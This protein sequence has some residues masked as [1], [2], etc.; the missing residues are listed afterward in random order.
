MARILW[1][2]TALAAAAFA[3]SDTSTL[4][5]IVR[6]ASDAT[7]AGASVVIRNEATGFERRTAT[8]DTGY[9][10]IASVPSGVYEVTVE[11]PGFKRYRETGRK[12]DPN[13]AATLAV[14]MQVGSVQESVS[15]VASAAEVQ[16][17]TATVGRIITTEQVNSLQLNG[18][19]PM[20]LAQ[21]APGV[22]RRN[23]IS[24]F[25]FGMDN[26]FFINGARKEE[27]NITFDG[28]PAVRTRSAGV[29]IGV[30]DLDATQEVQILTS[31]YRAEYGRASGGQMRIITK[32]GSKDFHGSFYEYFRNSALDAN[33]WTRNASGNPDF[34]SPAPFRFNQ[35]GYS[36][37]GPVL[38]PG[39]KFNRNRN[40]LFWLFGQEFVKYRQDQTVTRLVPSTA[41]RQGD[42]SELLSATNRYYGRVVAVRDPLNNTPFAGNI[43]PANRLSSSGI[44]LI[45]AFPTPTPGF[46]QGN[47]NWI[48]AAGAPQNQRKETVSVD[49]SPTEKHNFRFRFLNYN[50]DQTIPFQGGYDRGPRI[51]IRPNKVG[52]IN[53][54]W[55][56]NPSTVNELL[57]SASHD[58]TRI[59]LDTSSG[60]YERTQYGITY[61]FLFPNGKLTEN[62]IPAINIAGLTTLTTS[63][64]G[65]T[66]GPI[67]VISN[68][69]SKVMS[70]HTFKA[71]FVY[72]YAGQND[73]NQNVQ[74]GNFS[75]TDNRTG[76][77]TS[78]AAMAN[79]ALGMFDSY[80]EIGALNYI[81]YRAQMFEYFA[82]D[83]WKITQKFNLE[84]GLRHSLIQPWYSQWGNI[85]MFDSRFY[86][87]AKIPTLD[88]RTGRIL[89]GSL[90][91]GIVIPGDGF[92][93]AVSG[94]LPF[95]PATAAGLFR[96]LG[97]S[98]SVFHKTDFQP[99]VGITYAPTTRLVFRAGIGRYTLRPPVSDNVNPGANL[100]F[101]QSAS[102]AIG[103]VDSPGGGSTVSNPPQVNTWDATFRNPNAW[104]WNASAEW[105]VSQSTLLS[106]GYVARRG[107][108]NLFRDRNMNQL[109]PGTI[110]RNPGINV[111]FLRPFHGFGDI[112]LTNNDARSIYQ[113]LQM[114]LTRRY[115]KG[116][117]YGVAYTYSKAYDSGSSK[118]DILPNA[119]DA[120]NYWGPSANDFRNIL[121]VNFAYDLPFFANASRVPRALLGG[122]Q[123][124]GITQFQSGPPLTIQSAEDFAG[125][126]PG[127]GPQIWNVSGNPKLSGGER[128]FADAANLPNYWFRA[129]DGNGQSLFTPPATGTFTTQRNRNLI[130]GPG[131]QDWNL[132]VAKAFAF[133]ENHRLQFRAEVFNWVNHPNWAQPAANPRNLTTLGKITSK[134]GERNLQLSLRY[135]F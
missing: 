135:S 108:N 41:I 35:F 90:T 112:R 54:I 60:R 39:T 118:D 110:Q 106:V 22:I 6:D 104:N 100:P 121:I 70:R 102:I 94:R 5:G 105:G 92:P 93:E 53:Y 25:T 76:G 85:S 3:Q 46:S 27:T 117:L 23:S 18:R 114:N 61:P 124:A 131:F 19:N 57:V 17:E 21:L 103:P 109:Q 11:A 9:F 33:S 72:E 88:P 96:G 30:P 68:N 62:V 133:S 98:Y 52:S 34:A 65:L 115:S 64:P 37:S 71:G 125:V 1:A 128:K 4:S 26:N 51:L 13:I 122:W 28:A 75:F 50:Y 86:D 81:P 29:P 123:I 45:R 12:I 2:A 78:G 87:P 91:N 99:R 134:S 24:S 58:R 67:Y 44:G 132:S 10:A 84:Y 73:G 48:A 59:L 83:S 47:N 107:L 126:G 79:A 95:D 32:S 111:N 15:V 89:S 66:A 8:N 82:Q 56:V 14:S 120:S 101:Q 119:Y 74:S 69:F 42:F 97:K 130:Y 116:L 40:K 77:S 36:L 80:S 55:T 113:A 63:A 16:S 38:L 7:I 20:F 31:N 43:I 129:V 127:S 49:F